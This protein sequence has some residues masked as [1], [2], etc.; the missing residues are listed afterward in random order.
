MKKNKIVNKF[1]VK[2]KLKKGDEVIVISGKE[3]GKKGKIDKINRK[4]NGVII[5]GLNMVKKHKRSRDQQR[6]PEIVELPAVIPLSNVMLADPK[7]GKPTRIG[8]KI[9]NGKKVRYAKKSGAILK[10]K[11]ESTK[12]SK[13]KEKAKDKEINDSD[14][15][16]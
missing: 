4:K 3:R 12:K 8:Y 13:S 5:Q 16:V 10:D 2:T 6:K 11:T 7:T 14:A 9:E 15:V 1:D